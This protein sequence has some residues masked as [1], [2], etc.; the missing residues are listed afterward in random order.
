V[1]AHPDDEYSFAG[2]VYRLTR[3]AGWIA[4]QLIVTDGASGYRYAALAEMYYGVELTRGSEGR[5]RLAAIR[6]EEV[7]ASGKVLGIR[8]HHFLEQHD[9]GFETNAA[10]AESSNWDRVGIL[11]SLADLLRRNRYDIVFTMLPTADTHGHHRTATMLVL[12]AI[13]A[14]R[15]AVNLDRNFIEAIKELTVLGLEALINPGRK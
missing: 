9:L 11:A 10:T 7:R 6:K 3:E 5:A 12:E 8:E 13:A 1:V 14:L 2:S 4:D 15:K